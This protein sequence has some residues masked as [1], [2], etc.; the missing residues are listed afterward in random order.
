MLDL[1]RDYWRIQAFS[2]TSAKNSVTE[3]QNANLDLEEGVTYE[4]NWAMRQRIAGL[5]SV[6]QPVM[7][8]HGRKQRRP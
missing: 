4:V 1:R 7:R 2:A 3:R 5:I 6:G 8:S